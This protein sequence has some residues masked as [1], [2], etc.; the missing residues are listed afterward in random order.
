MKD[1]FGIMCR[2]VSSTTT[3]GLEM[4]LKCFASTKTAGTWMAAAAAYYFER[5]QRMRA[6]VETVSH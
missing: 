5:R 3:Y 6:S 2:R 1:C 4:E